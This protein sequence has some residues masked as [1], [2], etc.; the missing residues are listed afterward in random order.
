MAKDLNSIYQDLQKNSVNQSQKVSLKVISIACQHDSLSSGNFPN[1]FRNWFNKLLSGKANFACKS[2]QRFC[3]LSSSILWGDC[4][5]RTEN[6]FK[7]ILYLSCAPPW[8]DDLFLFSSSNCTLCG[9]I[10]K[11]IEVLKFFSEQVF[12][13]RP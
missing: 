7:S 9:K 11:V 8:G 5:N 6:E 13:N 10:A 3:V 4:K 12:T 2:T 1:G